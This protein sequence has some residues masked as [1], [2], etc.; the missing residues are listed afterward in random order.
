M[1]K[2]I[3]LATLILTLLTQAMS[4]IN[5]P[6]ASAYSGL[7]ID[8][9]TFDITYYQIGSNGRFRI[10]LYSHG[11]AT[12]LESLGV[13]LY[14]VK[15]DGTLYQSQFFGANYTD[16]PLLVP[17]NTQKVIFSHPFQIPN[18]QTLISGRFYCVT[19]ITYREHGTVE[20]TDYVYGPYEARSSD[21]C[22]VYNPL[23]PDYGSLQLQVGGLQANNTNLQSQI[24]ELQSLLSD[25]RARN[26]TLSNLTLIAII[27]AFIFV[28]ATIYLVRRKPRTK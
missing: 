2:E 8:G 1:K 3:P 26:V 15:T 5:S 27:V 9:P 17:A 28:D 4:T 11:D 25:T 14:F 10:G 12:D 24:N 23:Y 21:Y 7:G 20:Y 19:Y 13:Y 16:N 22:Y 6:T 18:E